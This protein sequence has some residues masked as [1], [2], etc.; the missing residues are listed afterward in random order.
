MNTRHARNQFIMM[1]FVQIIITAFI[2]LQWISVFIYSTFTTN[3]I[4]TPDQSAI[5]RFVLTLSN[6]CYYLNYVKSFY[7]SILTSKLFQKTLMKGLMNLLPRR[8]HHRIEI[9]MTVNT[10]RPEQRLNRRAPT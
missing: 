4:R 10:V 8:M 6:Y 3:Q 1:I 7:I 9:G 5:V 2:S